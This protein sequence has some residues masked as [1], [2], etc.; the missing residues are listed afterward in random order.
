MSLSRLVFRAGYGIR[1]L[2]VPDHCLFIYFAGNEESHK[3]LDDFDFVPNRTVYM[4]LSDE[5]NSHRLT[6]EKMLSGG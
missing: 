3:I 4:R 1:I 2:S 5:K 6:V